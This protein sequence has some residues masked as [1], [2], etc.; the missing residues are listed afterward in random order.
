MDSNFTFTEQ[1]KMYSENFMHKKR[2]INKTFY[3]S[4]FIFREVE[5][6]SQMIPDLKCQSEL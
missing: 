5:K 3:C 4:S 2:K 6:K 1:V